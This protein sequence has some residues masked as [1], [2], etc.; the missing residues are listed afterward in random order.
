MIDI[1][2]RKKN[3]KRY[4]GA[5]IYCKKSNENSRT[6]NCMTKMKKTNINISQKKCPD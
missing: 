4:Q 1:L 2:E 6:E 5:L 3:E